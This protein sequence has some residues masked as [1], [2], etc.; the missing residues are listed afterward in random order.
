MLISVNHIKK[1]TQ[2]ARASDIVKAR[3]AAIA[4]ARSGEVI[5][6]ANN[7]RLQGDYVRWS[8]HAEESL[9]RKLFKLKAFNRYK[10][11]TIFVFRISAKGISMARPC[12]RCQQ[13]LSRY[14][15]K[16]LYTTDEG[17]IQCL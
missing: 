8:M 7:R 2:V 15:V 11:I 14:N 12:I 5:C 17:K 1:A 4:I 10:N 3:M 16:V 6:T 13:L 9:I